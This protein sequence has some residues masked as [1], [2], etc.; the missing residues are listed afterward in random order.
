MT[1]S[2]FDF[3]S[4]HFLFV[5]GNVQAF[6][7]RRQLALLNQDGIPERVIEGYTRDQIRRWYLQGRRFRRVWVLVPITERKPR[8]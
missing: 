4:E 1:R 3:F 6:E 2:P 5:D 7:R 8:T